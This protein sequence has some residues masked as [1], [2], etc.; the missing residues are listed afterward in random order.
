MVGIDLRCN[1]G[2]ECIIRVHR[3]DWIPVRRASHRG[4][5]RNARMSVQWVIVSDRWYR[6]ARCRLRRM[7][8]WQC[9][10]LR[11]GLRRRWWWHLGLFD[12]CTSISERIVRIDGL[13]VHRR[14]AAARH[15]LNGQWQGWIAV[16]HPLS[17]R[18]QSRVAV[19]HLLLW[20]WRDR[21]ARGHLLRRKL[22]QRLVA[23]QRIKRID[24]LWRF[25]CSF[26]ASKRIGWCIGRRT[27][28]LLHLFFSPS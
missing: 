14:Q 21:S 8:L 2:I 19:Y 9:R 16:Y 26:D 5:V 22:W 10:R 12:S 27:I 15:F 13:V 28:L 3:Q 18:W 4:K 20:L 23:H 11:W 25:G 6:V 17:E 7:Y 24:R 1:F